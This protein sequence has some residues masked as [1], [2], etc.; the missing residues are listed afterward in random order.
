MCAPRQDVNEHRHPPSSHQRAQPRRS[1]RHHNRTRHGQR[2]QTPRAHADLAVVDLV[3][4]VERPAGLRERQHQQRDAGEQ[5]NRRQGSV[6]RRNKEIAED[7][8][9]DARD[10]QIAEA[11][12]SH[13]VT[14]PVRA[15]SVR[16]TPSRSAASSPDSR[17]AT[18]RTTPSTVSNA[19]GSSASHGTSTKAR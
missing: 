15:A 14:G 1:L 11:G 17:S 5:G 18:G 8:R 16:R 2:G 9:D 4:H 13:Y 3:A 10:Q 7:R 6:S 19:P 12:G